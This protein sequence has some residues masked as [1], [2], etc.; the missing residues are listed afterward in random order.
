MAIIVEDL[1]NDL[2]IR[3][4]H[5]GTIG[6]QQNGAEQGNMLHLPLHAGHLNVLA[7]PEWLGENDRQSRD[8]I[9]EDSLHGECNAGARDSQPGYQR[10]QLDTKVL[11][12]HD[13]EQQQHQ[14]AD[15]P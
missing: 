12:C 4:H 6:V 7:N 11:Q 10:Q 3:D 13:G 15:D 14:P 8:D 1:A 9:A 2:A 5:L